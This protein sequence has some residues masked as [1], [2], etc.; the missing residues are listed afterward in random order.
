MSVRYTKFFLYF[1][2]ALLFIAGCD[3]NIPE[4]QVAEKAPVI[5]EASKP[6][7]IQQ[8]P[9]VF[10]TEKPLPPVS[11]VVVEEKSS[12]S[13]PASSSASAK[14]MP[15]KV[16][17]KSSSAG[18]DSSKIVEEPKFC[19]IVPDGMVCDSRDGKM[20][21]T[22]RIGRQLWLAQNMNHRTEGSWCYNNRSE[23]CET[24]GRLYDWAAAMDL[25]RKYLSKTTEGL[26]SAK[27]QGVCM[28]GWHVPSE[29]DMKT[30]VNYVEEKNAELE[31][32]VEAVGTSLKSE[33]G[34]ANC[35]TEDEVCVPPTNRY[36]FGALPAGRR[37]ADGSFNDIG[38]DSGFWISAES[39]NG[40]HA[41]YWDLYYSSDK[42]W[43][44]YSN[45]K[46]V[47]YSV[48]CIKD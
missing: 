35:E 36:G 31:G 6:N 24:I 40:I 14:R 9:L 34:W 20:Y 46:K 11:S 8:E 44:S 38:Y 33:K 3:G 23:T 45:R 10:K 48:R 5:T 18:V 30:L 47:A 37:H 28:E 26:L 19:T 42:F 32:V 1:V 16:V 29:Q 13:A 15:K 22:V 17:A 2:F 27:H 41:P 43:G 39:P 4:K 21:R 12:D 7:E 25:P